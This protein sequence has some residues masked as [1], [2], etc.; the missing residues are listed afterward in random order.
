M[1]LQSFPTVELAGGDVRLREMEADDLDALMAIV[2]DETT[3]AHTTIERIPSRADEAE[4]LAGVVAHRAEEPRLRYELGVVAAGE[5]I[6][7]ARLYVDRP[8]QR[9]GD[10]GYMIRR[11]HW[12]QG[13]ATAATRLLVRFGFD[14]IGLHRIWAC[15][16]PDNSASGRVLE[17]A[18]L[19]HEGRIRDHLFVRGRWRDS[20]TYS[21]LEHERSP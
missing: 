16:D 17:K 21:I 1:E 14:E 4:F 11:D 3:I 15:H 6:G 10:L 12:G 5:F 13:V 2:S 8:E 9:C 20:V 7:L 18:G 19:T